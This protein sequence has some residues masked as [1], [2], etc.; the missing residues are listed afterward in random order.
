MA[1]LRGSRVPYFPCSARP[2]NARVTQWLRFRHALFGKLG[3]LHLRPAEPETGGIRGATGVNMIEP[4]DDEPTAAF[5]T[6]RAGA[7][8]TMTATNDG[9]DDAT[10]AAA[11]ADHRSEGIESAYRAHGTALFALAQHLLR[12]V[13]DAQDCVHDALLRAWQRP[14]AYR[15]ERGALRPFLMTCV[16]NESLS[17]L[18]RHTCHR[19]IEKRIA[20]DDRHSYEFEIGDSVEGGRLRNA[21]AALPTEQRT[22][23]SLAYFDNL[24]HIEI[25]KRLGVPLGTIKSRLSLGLRKLAALLPQAGAAS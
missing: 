13:D 21:L 19:R 18:R 12:D 22:A 8:W 11:F 3:A 15:P 23:L 4:N 7:R 10:I 2:C 6:G 1:L 25:A 20:H 5:A 16:R 17:R 14:D 24:T 9:A